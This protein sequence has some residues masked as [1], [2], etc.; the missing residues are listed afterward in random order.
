VKT[1]VTVTHATTFQH[2][3]PFHIQAHY[4]MSAEDKAKET[5]V[6]AERSLMQTAQA[7][8]GKSKLC[9]QPAA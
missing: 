9:A 8:G 6:K 4:I 5:A 2:L 7:W 1:I 3:L